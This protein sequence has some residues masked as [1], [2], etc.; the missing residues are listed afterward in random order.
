MLCWDFSEKA[1]MATY[2]SAEGN[3][4]THNLYVGNAYLIETSE[5]EE[6]GRKLYTV[7]DFFLDKDHFKRCLGLTKGSEGNILDQP[8]RKLVAITLNKKY[9]R[10]AKEI[11]G[12]LIQ[13]FDDLDIKIINE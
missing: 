5:W 9:C 8:Y 6:D 10:K 11:A 12:F 3:K 1:G 13:A 7:S 4:T 2:V